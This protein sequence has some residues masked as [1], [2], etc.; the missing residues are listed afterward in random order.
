MGAPQTPQTRICEKSPLRSRVVPGVAPP[1]RADLARAEAGDYGPP[2]RMWSGA[3]ENAVS[4][5]KKG[6]FKRHGRFLD[7]R[8][9]ASYR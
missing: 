1:H 8:Q 2:S 9:D 7:I 4:P 6:F 3:A 5:E